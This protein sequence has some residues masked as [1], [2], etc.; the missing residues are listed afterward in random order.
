MSVD[1]RYPPKNELNKYL[2]EKI[3]QLKYLML[4]KRSINSLFQ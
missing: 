3:H 1:N 4:I 2:H